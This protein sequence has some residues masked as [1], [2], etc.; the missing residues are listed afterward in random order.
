M[1]ANTRRPPRVQTTCVQ[2]P[3]VEGEH[4][5]T[6]GLAPGAY[7]C[8]SPAIE[9]SWCPALLPPPPLPPL[10][11][12]ASDDDDDDGDGLGGGA[13]AGIAVGCIVAGILIG[14]LATK[15]I[16]RPIMGSAYTT[17]GSKA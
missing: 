11:P 7:A 14:F 13:V 17:D 9:Y 8:A 10:P 6:T 3:F 4:Y 16:A 1:C 12:P 15:V 2:V 5:R